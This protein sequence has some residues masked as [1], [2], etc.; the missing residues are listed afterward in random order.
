MDAT[1]QRYGCRLYSTLFPSY[2]N[3]SHLKFFFHTL[4][5]FIFLSRKCFL[6]TRNQQC[7]ISRLHEIKR[8]SCGSASK[9]LAVTRKTC[10]RL[11]KLI[12]H[13][14]IA[15]GELFA[16]YKAVQ[17]APTGARL[18]LRVDNTG[19]LQ[20]I[21]KGRFREESLNILLG[22]LLEELEKGNKLLRTEW[23]PTTTMESLGADAISRNRFPIEGYT[24]SKVFAKK[25]QQRADRYFGAL[26][27]TFMVSFTI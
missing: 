10:T 22:L 12:D 4:F 18:L 7:K 11:S 23:V 21:E 16:I 15:Y 2:E 27:S 24:V 13:P 6:N 25:L 14:K 5:L 9:S 3:F 17:I 20:G 19:V 8:R 26:E 1:P